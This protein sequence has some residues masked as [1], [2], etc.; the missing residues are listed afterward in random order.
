MTTLHSPFQL[1]PK[2]GVS[3]AKEPLRKDKDLFNPLEL[4]RLWEMVQS[5]IDEGRYTGCQIAM[6]QEGE[7]LM[8]KNFGWSRLNTLAP[9]ES[10]AVQDD[11]LFLL[12]SNTKIMI[13]TLLW[14]LFEQG[15]L[16]FSDTVCSYLEDFGRHGKGGITLFQLITHQAGFPNQ[17]VPRDAWLDHDRV[18]KAVCDFQLEW[19][20]GSKVFYHG[21]SAHWV[22]A[23]VIEKITGVDFRQAVQEMVLKPLGLEKDLFMGLPPQNPSLAQKVAFLYEPQ[24]AQF[25]PLALDAAKD[26]ASTCAQLA[27]SMKLREESHDSVWQTAGVPGGGAYG[28][29]KGMAMLYQMMVQGGVYK[30]V[31]FLSE[32]TLAYAIQNY[33]GERVDEMMGMPMHRGLGPHLRGQSVHIRGLGTLS[34]PRVFGHGGVGTSYAWADPERKFSFAYITNTRLADPWHSKRLESVSNQVQLAFI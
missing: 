26:R 24:V 15:R 31:R 7:V 2:P 20:P 30:G 33:T 32:K 13:A 3:L 23:M 11:T 9:N 25:K 1:E 17:E 27:Q 16:S 34:G 29:A 28:T 12:Y 5:H 19:A 22:L 21:L 18:L 10:C 14:K 8:V 6:A 4:D